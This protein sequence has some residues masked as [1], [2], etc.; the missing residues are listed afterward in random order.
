MKKIYFAILF[1][2]MAILMSVCLMNNS[3]NTKTSYKTVKNMF[4]ELENLNKNKLSS[5][6]LT[7][8]SSIKN[9]NS[10]TYIN[11]N[12]SD[13]SIN[14]IISFYSNLSMKSTSIGWI[15]KDNRILRTEDVWKSYK[16]ITPY[17]YKIDSSYY[18]MTPSGVFFYDSNT[19]WISLR[20]H[21]DKKLT[22]YHTVDGGEHW[23]KTYLP[24]DKGWECEGK[25]YISFIN[26]KIGFI[27]LTST[28]ACSMMN[29]SIYKTIDGG[30][31]WKKVGDIT[32]KIASYPTGITFS[33]DMNGWITSSYHGQ[34]F[35][36][37]FKTTDSGVDWIKE[38]LQI[39]SNCTDGYYTNVYPPIFFKENKEKGILP[40]EYVNNDLGDKFIIPYMTSNR[41]YT[42]SVPNNFKNYKLKIYSFINEKQWWGIDQ[43][44]NKL[45]V[46]N[47]SGEN[48]N[49]I[50]KNKMFKDIKYIEF[51]NK[52]VGFAIGDYIFI[53]T[54][55]GGKN[56]FKIN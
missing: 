20:T 44:N 55:D 16:D 49:E 29:K 10:N 3:F 34:N 50:C 54:V 4:N 8:N 43:K 56:W 33:N 15:V 28:P 32:N 39:I 53:K 1:S 38:N 46:T 42:W 11:K 52:K 2:I 41:G 5:C 40:I 51:V 30:V 7:V 24:V 12:T 47:T 17:K 35:I 9:K 37:A 27:L 48:W 14:N 6:S 21:K 23:Y 25:Q 26:N 13:S 19:A 18:E 36:L 31:N 22:I 45:Y